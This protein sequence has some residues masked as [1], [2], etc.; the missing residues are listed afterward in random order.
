[1]HMVVA[2]CFR[3]KRLRHAYS[4][5]SISLLK[6]GSLHVFSD[7]IC[8]FHDLCECWLFTGQGAIGGDVS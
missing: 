3:I 8:S 7:D 2:E 5:G 6:L 1:M 4:S